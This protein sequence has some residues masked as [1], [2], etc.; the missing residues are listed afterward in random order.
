MRAVAAFS[1]MVVG[2]VPFNFPI[3]VPM[4]TVPIALTLGN[5]V[6]VKPSEKVPLTLTKVRTAICG[7]L[8]QVLLTFVFPLWFSPMVRSSV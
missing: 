8:L 6:I 7:C 1:L 2:Q 3:M 4:W 5:C